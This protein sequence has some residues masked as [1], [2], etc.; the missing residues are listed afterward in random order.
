MQINWINHA[1]FELES[2]DI[3]L[4]TD[5][6]LEGSILNNSWDLLSQTQYTPERM[7]ECTH[8]W[9]SHEHPD[10]FVPPTIRQIPKE[11]RAGITVL[12]KATEDRKVV[13]YCEAQGFKI[14]ELEEGKWLELA[15]DFRVLM[16]EVP[17][18]DTWLL[19]EAEGKRVLN[20]ND[21][22]VNHP[23]KAQQLA[24]TVGQDLDLLIS[25]FSYANW[26]GNPG[27]TETLLNAADE[28]LGRLD[29]ICGAL[30]PR[31]LLLSASFVWFSHDENFYLNEGV[32]PIREVFNYCRDRL[33]A[34]VH[35][36]APGQ[37]LDVAELEGH[38]SESALQAYDADEASLPNRERHQ[39]VPTQFEELQALSREYDERIAKRNNVALIRLLDILRIWRPTINIY[40]W[41]IDLLVNYSMFSGLSRCP[42]DAAP[43]VKMASD[44]LAFIFRHDFG[45]DSLE[46]GGRFNCDHS[47]RWK[48][49]RAFGI[50]VLNNMGKSFG[51]RLALDGLILRRAFEKITHLG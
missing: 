36:M 51:F 44:S 8:L 12:Y 11:A 30:K 35:V 47:K 10:H 19:I 6:W 1:G 45:F 16:G 22:V 24:Q 4:L 37:S 34:R 7:A 49:Y 40:L 29:Y 15:P 33:D 28:K 32:K 23:R 41:D 38:D 20:L 18:Y 14:V 46:A 13:K 50:A 2:G 3:C 17:F 9:F 39:A 42:A 27:E 31:D 43:D 48:M 26:V 25:Q 5:P 21:C